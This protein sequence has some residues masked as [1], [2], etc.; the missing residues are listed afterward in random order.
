MRKTITAAVV[1]ALM[2]TTA[3]PA[4]ANDAVRI[5]AGILGLVIN[6]VSKNRQSGGNRGPRNKGDTLIGRVGEEPRQSQNRRAGNGNKV[7]PAAAVAVAALALPE[8]G[9]LPEAK[10]TPEEMTAYIASLDTAPLVVSGEAVEVAGNGDFPIVGGADM[11]QQGKAEAYD[12]DRPKYGTVWNLSRTKG[13][14]FDEY[15]VA[16]G[17]V[18]PEVALAIDKATDGGMKRS[19]AIKQ[20]S[21][22]GEPGRTYDQIAERERQQAESEAEQARIAETFRLKQEE[23]RK[24]AEAQRQA[25]FEARK[26]ALAEAEAERVRQEEIAAKEA[27]EQRLRD[28]EAAIIGK[29]APLVDDSA[30]TAS[31][32]PE[33]APVVEPKTVLETAPA[34]AETKV[35]LDL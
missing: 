28:Q 23:S 15:R 4:F 34:T 29:A 25:A 6:E 8:V 20:F 1:A 2:T 14:V 35:D 5:G 11:A 22:Y 17:D 9:P 27:E 24:Q 3:A 19:D 30:K 10:P 21:P 18:S 16:W 13:T 33:V 32:T 31:V 26:K 12:F 7:A